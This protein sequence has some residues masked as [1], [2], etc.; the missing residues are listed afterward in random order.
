M[1][2]YI[3]YKHFL[4]ACVSVWHMCAVHLEARRGF[5]LSWDWTES[6][7]LSCRNWN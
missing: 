5:R 1:Y 3:M 6:C 4:P 7:E 2:I